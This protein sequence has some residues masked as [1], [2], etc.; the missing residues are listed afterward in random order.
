MTWK[1]LL[2]LGVALLLIVSWTATRSRTSWPPADPAAEKIIIRQIGHQLLRQAGDSTSRILPVE[3][4]AAGQ[5]LLRFSAPFVFIPDS[6]VAT[7]AQVV[8]STSLPPA[9]LVEVID[10]SA[11]S[12]VIFGYQIA[13]DTAHNVVACLGREQL[14][15]CYNIKLTF[16]SGQQANPFSNGLLVGSLGAIGLGLLMRALY[17]RKTMRAVLPQE[18]VMAVNIPSP[19]ADNIQEQATAD[20]VSLP[21][22]PLA[23]APIPIGSLL[24]YKDSQQLLSGKD[25]IPLT[26]KEA[27]LLQVFAMAQQ[28]VIDR[29]QLMK[30]VW[31]DEGVIVGR[32]L[33]MF[34]SKL[35]KKLQADPRVSIIN[36]HGKGYKLAIGLAAEMEA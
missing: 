4:L 15:A 1:A 14:K 36:V 17:R 26:A 24:F 35:R 3:E 13:K 28:E 33:D 9:Y 6:L 5:Y 16:K 31:E 34:V 20:V 2:V 8:A 32:S 18:P 10:C 29:N 11:P 27:K 7:V 21:A 12:Q 23:P 19:V 22:D 25:I 30:E